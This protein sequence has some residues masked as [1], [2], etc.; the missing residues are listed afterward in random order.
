MCISIVISLKLNYT[1]VRKLL[2]DLINLCKYS[3]FIQ[4]DRSFI[5][6]FVEEITKRRQEIKGVVIIVDEKDAEYVNNVI[7]GYLNGITYVVAS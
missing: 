7:S 3:I 5:G 2:P 6:E 4:I 1:Q